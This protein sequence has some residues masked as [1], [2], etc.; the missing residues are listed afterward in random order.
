[1]VQASYNESGWLILMFLYVQVGESL[2]FRRVITSLDGSILSFSSKH[3]SPRPPRLLCP[4][5][6][7]ENK[8]PAIIYGRGSEEKVG[9]LRKIFDGQGVG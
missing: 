9:G 6:T 3:R 2:W 1:M 4:V 7:R 5:S 8:G